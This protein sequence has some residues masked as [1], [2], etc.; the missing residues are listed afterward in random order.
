M[1]PPQNKNQQTANTYAQN[2]RM[3][4]VYSEHQDWNGWKNAHIQLQV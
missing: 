1:T 2:F 4:Y 3:T